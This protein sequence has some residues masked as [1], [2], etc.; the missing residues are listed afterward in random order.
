MIASS[1]SYKPRRNPTISG[2]D[3]S[4]KHVFTWKKCQAS[5]L[6]SDYLFESTCRCGVFAM[7]Y[8]AMPTSY[9][10]YAEEHHR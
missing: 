10:N 4:H 6:E 3:G 9:G 8:Y 2:R 1:H 5:L 7:R